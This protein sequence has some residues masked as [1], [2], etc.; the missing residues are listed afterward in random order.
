[1]HHDPDVPGVGPVAQLRARDLP[2][3]VPTLVAVLEACA[4]AALDIE[5]KNLPT[6]PGFDPDHGV[7]V[8]LGA[9]L[10]DGGAGGGGG[11]AG[12]SPVL[13]SSFWPDTL[14]ALAGADQASRE[15]GGPALALLVHPAF[16]LD[17]ALEA[18]LGLGC[19]AL[20]PHH[21]QVTADL[22]RRCHDLGM[23][24]VTWTVN[25][26]AELDAVVGAGVDAVVTDQVEA[27]LV[28][29]GRA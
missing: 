14:G 10:A 27:T 21:S 25:L 1:V 4:G 16:D 15:A 20:N 28:R 19:A 13:V 8:D 17:S 11:A 3:H 22:V 2:A 23:A 5:V 18:A 26:P 6:E 24:V 9:L 7:A 12:P 29:L